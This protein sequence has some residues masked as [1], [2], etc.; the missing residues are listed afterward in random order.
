M[1]RPF[2]MVVRLNDKEVPASFFNISDYSMSA[3]MSEQDFLFGE[4]GQC[5]AL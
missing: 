3:K 2:S 4:N 5:H 1:D